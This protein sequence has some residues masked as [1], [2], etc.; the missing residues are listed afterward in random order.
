MKKFDKGYLYYRL[1]CDFFAVLFFAFCLLSAL[2]SDV[3]ETAYLN[4][5]FFKR[6]LIIFVIIYAIKTGYNVLYWHFSRYEVGENE[7]KC[8]RGVLYRKFSVL[9]YSKIHAINKKQNILQKIF[10]IAVLTIDSGSANTGY[11]AEILIIE[12]SATVD[13][14]MEMVRGKQSGVP[15][16]KP[17][18]LEDPCDNLYEFDSRLKLIYSALLTFLSLVM[19]LITLVVIGGLIGTA[20]LVYAKFNGGS[21][22][23]KYFI[24]ALIAI[25]VISL[26]SFVF[27]LI[28]AHLRFYKFLL[29]KNENGVTIS[30][31]L[32]SRNTDTFSL[33]RIKGV[34]IKQNII[35]RLF[36]F[37]TVNIE[38]VGFT[39]GSDGNQNSGGNSSG[40]LIPLCKM[41]EVKETLGKI[42]P[43]YLPDDAQFKPKKLTPFLILKCLFPLFT[44]VILSTVGGILYMLYTHNLINPADGFFGI[45]FA[46]TLVLT[47]I[48]AALILIHA[49][50]EKSNTGLSFSGDKITAYCG[51]FTKKCYV[52]LKENFIALESFTTPLHQKLDAYTYKIHFYTNA[53]QNEVP[54]KYL[55]GELEQNLYAHLNK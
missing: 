6:F 25:P 36:G 52:I 24:I 45:Y 10:N 14:L 28:G 48:I 35:Q 19:M 12:K 15:S 39:P 23:L 46:V 18:L 37:C 16:E 51:G 34:I 47:A 26:I 31:G 8:R 53:L 42:L 9:E 32:L 17:K 20:A 4:G 49:L 40:V 41:K 55:Q 5:E 21:E 33:K 13:R 7:I 22:V 11:S 43:D 54:V 27:G 38:V 2:Y 44:A 30:Y 1:I 29:Y 3:E 50:L